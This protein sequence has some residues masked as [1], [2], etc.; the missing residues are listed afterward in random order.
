MI[1]RIT[2]ERM[3]TD[4]CAVGHRE[5][6][7]TIFVEQGAP[8]DIANV[9]ITDDKATFSRG[10]IVDI[11]EASSLRALPI[12]PFSSQCGGCSWQ[13]LTYDAQLAAKRDNIVSALSHL[14]G[15]SN[16][17]AETMVAPVLRSK[18]EW[19]YR[20]KLELAASNDANGQLHVGFHTEK[21][22]DLAFVERCPL[23]HKPI[24]KA[25]KALRGALRYLQGNSDLGIFRV[26]VRGSIRTKSLEIALWTKPSSFPRAT[27]AK[28]LSGAL[29]HTSSIVRILADPGKSRTIK[30]VETLE[31]K[32]MWEENLCDCRFLTS[33][34][35]F[36][37]VNTAQAEKLIE[38]A[39]RGLSDA[40]A[41]APVDMDGMYVADLYAGGGTFSIPLA[42]AGADVV[43]IEA[44]GPSVRDLRRNADVNNVYVDVIGGDA[45]RQ[46]KEI[47]GR[48]DALVVDP[49]RAGLAA[50]VVQDIA[51]LRPERVAYVSCNPT[52]W[53]RDIV[54]FEEHGYQLA[55]VQPVDMFPQTFH[56][57]VVS[58]FK[59]QTGKRHRG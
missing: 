47:E 26:G 37:Q 44:S 40:A 36:F 8:G 27:A 51:K 28:V 7:K 19:G 6:G 22:H 1:E 17:D 11:L 31:G 46:I 55:S 29:P 3:G 56:V 48:L 9:E 42:K 52:T 16:E 12:C 10:R 24:E 57:E 50:S 21:S 20:N 43:A 18:R 5:N 15:F 54:R 2:L 13:H 39:M 38:Q 45:A 49:P 58:I 14:G 59:R 25:P 4:A 32:G 35:S 41:G 53:T 30:R 23:A 34:P 33:A